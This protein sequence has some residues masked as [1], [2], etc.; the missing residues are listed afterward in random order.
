[1]HNASGGST[2]TSGAIAG[3]T[4]GGLA[5]ILIAAIVFWLLRKKYA[6]KGK[7]YTLADLPEYSYPASKNGY[8]VPESQPRTEASMHTTPSEL[9]PT[10]MEPQELYGDVQRQ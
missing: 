4:V 2:N 8:V 3:G 6:K 10:Q 9:P 7:D 5:A 1:M